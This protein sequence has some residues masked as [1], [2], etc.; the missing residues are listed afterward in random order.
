VKAAIMTRT[1]K[2]ALSLLAI[3]SLATAQL[4]Q[5][6]AMQPIAGD[7]VATDSGRIAGT[8]L[9]AGIRAYLGIPFA[10]PPVRALRWAAPQPIHWDGVWNADRKGAACIQVLRPHNINHYFGEEATS[11]DCLTLN[12]WTPEKSSEKNLPVVVFLYGGGFTIGSSGMANYDGAALAARGAVAINFNYRVGAFGFMAHPELSREAGG[13]SGNYG[14]MDQIAALRWVR[15]NVARFGGDPDR[16][17][18]IG[19]SAGASSVASLVYAPQAKG[20]FRSAVMSSGCNVR[21]PKP[22]LADAEAIGLAV[23]KRLGAASLAAMRDIPADRIL[24]VQSES[25]VGAHVEGVRIGGPII[26]GFVQPDQPVAMTAAGTPNRVPMIGVYTRD[27]ID[28][29]MSPFAAVRTLADYRA[30]A[31]R[32]FG[33]DAPAFLELFPASSDDQAR[34]AAQDAARATGFALSARQCAQD[35]AKLGQSAWIGLFAHK[36]PYAPGVTF[37]DQDPAT[38]GVYHTADVPYWLG[39][40]DAYNSLRPTRAWTDADRALSAQMADA[41]IGFAA[42]GDPG[43]FWP[44]WTPKGEAVIRLDTPIR[45]ERFD[46]RTMNWLDAHPVA[47]QPLAPRPGLPRD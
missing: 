16:V 47:R 22:T 17:T 30:T 28:I 37:A 5:A 44:R 1:R 23:Q 33:K 6:A 13:H 38:I 31:D 39:T 20:L 29:G 14:L 36:H 43:A 4:A 7:P 25:Q 46:S 12:L 9:P 15:A 8:Q 27:D 45:V 18:I 11:E 40:L 19:Q 3:A 21:S 42:D 34:A 24:A 2:G 10:A 35:E 41:L 32:L 26:D